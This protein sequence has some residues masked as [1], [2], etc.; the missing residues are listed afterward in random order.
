MGRT[1]VFRSVI[2][3]AVL[4]VGFAA[5]ALCRAQ[6]P[7]AAP[8]PPPATAEPAET[9][10][11][12]ATAEPVETT[13]PP[14]EAEPVESAAAPVVAEAAPADTEPELKPRFELY[15]PSAR[16]LASELQRSRSGKFAS[17]LSRMMLELADSSAEGV[18][19]GEA[20]ALAQRIGDWPD[21]AIVVSVFAPDTEG[22]LRWAARF[23]WSV[24]DLGKRIEALI[25]LE[26]A[27][28]MFEGL[29]LNGCGESGYE[30]VLRDTPLG[31]L[32]PAGDAQ[33]YVQ[34]HADLPLP[35][36][37]FTGTEETTKD[38]APLVVCRLN[39]AG[40][41]KDSGATFMSSFNIVTDV[42][43][44]GRV[45][46]DGGWAEEVYVHWP[47]IAG[48]GAKA[49][50]GKVKQTFFVPQEAFAA[51]A[52]KTVAAPGILE[53]MAGLGQQVIMES[54][55]QIT[56]MGDPA[57]GPL[58][59]A[60]GTELCVT[61]MPGTGFLP[62]P[63]IVVQAKI[64]DPEELMED[65]ELAAEDVNDELR[66]REQPAAWRKATVRERTVIWSDG[67]GH[68]PGAYLPFIMR[69][70]LF[71]TTETDALGKD[72]NFLVMGWTT[73]SPRNF[74]RRW[75][76]QPR[77][78][79]RHLP[80]KK[81][82][83]GQMWVNWG[84]VYKWIAPYANTALSAVVRDSLL[85]SADDMAAD[86]TDGLVTMKTRYSGLRVAHT[87]PLPVGAF[88]VPLLAGISAA[89]DESG[90]SDLARERLASQRLKVLYH[91]SKL[92]HKDV[93]RWPAEVAELEGYV[94]FAGNPGLLHL[95]LSSRK[96]RSNWFEGLFEV[97]DEE[98]LEEE[99]EE[100][101]VGVGIDDDLYVIEWGRD[102]W[103][104]GLAPDTLEHLEKL[105]IDQDGEVHRVV[106]TETEEGKQESEGGEV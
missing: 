8:T 51:A 72:K 68:V 25:K 104:L 102:S 87:G 7:K 3:P 66:E 26:A 16:K 56:V 89:P 94:D 30:L 42:V 64:K 52:F 58:V 37:P 54:P 80:L 101:G 63:D 10:P 85:P 71:A 53:Q 55:G 15:V 9:A 14:A 21:S 62:A 73:T 34:S 39:L 44:A 22:R 97:E 41:E 2:L 65:L 59:A 24:E 88:V 76:D 79:P 105:Y 47:P 19:V 78:D 86:L 90:E 17:L 50:F 83:N 81:K 75:L 18:D 29:S 48:M 31:I 96:A 84:Q 82:T 12:P 20:T 70:V 77:Q 46:E 106:K 32:A 103:R 28:E 98:E 13:P 23:D 11:P 49:M 95:E 74:V 92:F 6:T 36:K 67:T 45:A 93:G 43:Y 40:T 100:G 61:L 27:S 99:E 4:L 38:G 91:H 69:P 5:A 1:I 57:P 35:D 60:V 33:A